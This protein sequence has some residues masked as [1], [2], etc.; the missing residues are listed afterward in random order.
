MGMGLLLVAHRKDLEEAKDNRISCLYLFRSLSSNVKVF[1]CNMIISTRVQEE[2]KSRFHIAEFFSAD[3][4]EHC[5][6]TN[7]SESELYV[8]IRLTIGYIFLNA[9]VHLQ[10][11][12][13]K[14]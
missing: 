14:L 6:K 5:G 8:I 4:E 7:P 9:F 13:K 1:A 12:N 2:C 11:R 3:V 10:P